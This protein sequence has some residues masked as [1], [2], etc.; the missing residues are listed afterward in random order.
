MICEKL[1]RC[2]EAGDPK[3]SDCAQI[4]IRIEGL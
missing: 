4:I 1:N 2:F 3:T